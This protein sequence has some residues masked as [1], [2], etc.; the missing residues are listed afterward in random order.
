[1]RRLT[2]SLRAVVGYADLWVDGANEA[3]G[4]DL[5]QTISFTD[6]NSGLT[7]RAMH[8]DCDTGVHRGRDVVLQR[9]PR[10]DRRGLGEHARLDGL[11]WLEGGP[12]GR[13]L[14]SAP[15]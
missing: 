14:V 15:A 2:S 1:M 7:Y 3:V 10:L 11:D 5:A 13:W 4:V 6:P 12:T 9:A 8:F